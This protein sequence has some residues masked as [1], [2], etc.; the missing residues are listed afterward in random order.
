M[1]GGGGGGGRKGVFCF[2]LTRI[3][4]LKNIVLGNPTVQIDWKQ[5]LQVITGQE[6]KTEEQHGQKQMCQSA[7]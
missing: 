5:C 2:F 6:A 4:V 1:C 3:S 7:V